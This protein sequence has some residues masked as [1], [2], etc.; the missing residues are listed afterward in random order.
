VKLKKKNW[1]KSYGEKSKIHQGGSWGRVEEGRIFTFPG[2]I[3][4]PNITGYHT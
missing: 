2:T 1:A 4:K 3:A